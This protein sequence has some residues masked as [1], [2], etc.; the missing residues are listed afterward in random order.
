[1][2][3]VGIRNSIERKRKGREMVEG[4]SRRLVS[5]HI[6]GLRRWGVADRYTQI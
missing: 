2:I 6:N 3:K 4:Q 1:M 5:S